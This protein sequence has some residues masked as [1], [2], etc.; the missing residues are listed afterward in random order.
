M[1]ERAVRIAQGQEAAGKL[2]IPYVETSSKE[3]L[4]GINKLFDKMIEAIIKKQ[5]VE[6]RKAAPV[7]AVPK[8]E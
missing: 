1:R 2:G 6:I 8:E 3:V 7:K 4:G 5:K